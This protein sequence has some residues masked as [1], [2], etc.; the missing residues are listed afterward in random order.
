MRRYSAL[1]AIV[2]ALGV[3]ALLGWAVPR[4]PSAPV[5]T[6]EDEPCNCPPLSDFEDRVFPQKELK[7]WEE[8]QAVYAALVKGKVDTLLRDKQAGKVIDEDRLTAYSE[9]QA[10]NNRRIRIRVL[11]THAWEAGSSVKDRRNWLRQLREEFPKEYGD[12]PSHAPIWPV[13]PTPPVPPEWREEWNTAFMAIFP[14][15][16]DADRFPPNEIL[17]EWQRLQEAYVEVIGGKI[18]QMSDEWEAGGRKGDLTLLQHYERLERE[19]F[20]LEGIRGDMQH[21]RHPATDEFSSRSW[22]RYLRKEY[23]EEYASGKWPTPIPEVP[24]E[25][26]A[27][28]DAGYARCC[29]IIR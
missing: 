14:P 7:D 9:L 22:L 20:H 8:Q 12:G 3:C 24:P 4:S 5:R 13:N 19:V 29:Q 6:L 28:F 18:R 10:E 16:S 21:I 25:L 27:E 15:L 17:K 26:Q 2:G 11:M 1:L 23:P